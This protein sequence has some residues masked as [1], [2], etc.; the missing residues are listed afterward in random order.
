[1]QDRALKNL[2]RFLENDQDPIMQWDAT[3]Y[4]IERLHGRLVERKEVTG[5]DGGALQ[6]EDH[7][8]SIK[9]LLQQVLNPPEPKVIDVERES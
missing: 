7:T 3:R 4:V 2:K 1:M 6:I 8:P 5:A 9:M